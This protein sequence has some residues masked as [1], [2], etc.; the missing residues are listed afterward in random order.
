VTWVT[1]LLASS[2][3]H[4]YRPFDS[5]DAA[6]AK[7]GELEAEY[8]PFGYFQNGRRHFLVT[9]SLIINAGFAPGWE[10]VLQ[11]RHFVLLDRGSNQVHAQLTETAALLKGVLRQGSLQGRTGLSIGTEF[12][13]LLPN[14]NG[15][16]GVGATGL[17]ILSQR[18]DAATLHVNGAV[19]LTRSRTW[20]V[21]GGVILE[22]SQRW[23]VRPVAELFIDREVT[24]NAALSGLIGSIWRTSSALSLDIG[25]RAAVVASRPIY[26]LRGGLTWA[27]PLTREP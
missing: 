11:G 27:F 4:A 8:G 14:V 20:A 23:I 24:D 9:P 12:G 17:L 5:T 6:V 2:N 7:V 13:C 22:G 16:T 10:I 25:A 3:A 21:F 19:S 15:D 26:E 1:T 18:W